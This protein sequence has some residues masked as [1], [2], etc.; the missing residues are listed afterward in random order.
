MA[1]SENLIIKGKCFI[2]TK[3]DIKDIKNTFKSLMYKRG[4]VSDTYEHPFLE[5][6]FFSLT[7][8]LNS[9]NHEMSLR[10]NFMKKLRLI[11][12]KKFHQ[13]QYFDF[14]ISRKDEM[15]F[16]MNFLFSKG[17]KK[18]KEGYL[19]EVTS[20][21]TIYHKISQLGYSFPK[22]EFRYSRIIS[23]NEEFVYEIMKSIGSDI[24][25]KPS[26]VSDFSKNLYKN[27]IINDLKKYKF[28]KVSKILEDGQGK[29]REGDMKGSLDEFRSVIEIFTKEITSRIS[30]K[31]HSQDKVKN[32][33]EIL[34]N[35][36]IISD[37]IFGILDS[38]YAKKLYPFISDNIHKRNS[39]TKR[40]VEYVLNL[41]ESYIEYLIK[42]VIE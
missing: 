4:F 32:N 20:K 38:I 5:N 8:Y 13:V 37:E 14:M 26:V 41:I 40:D 3:S 33:L 16:Q 12:N 29:L 34:K 9:H 6:N 36:Q 2:E 42:K 21:P 11:S 7:F 27:S 24:L 17:N 23:E 1:K 30:S 15:P 35:N 31:N 39:L 18:K 22:S 19:I 28:E 25:S 10:I